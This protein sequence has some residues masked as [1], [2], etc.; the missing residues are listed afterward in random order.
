MVVRV[1][2]IINNLI[3]RTALSR[4]IKTGHDLMCKGQAVLN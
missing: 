4:F 1:V 3:D 2:A